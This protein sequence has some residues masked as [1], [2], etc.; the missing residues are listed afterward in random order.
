MLG[1]QIFSHTDKDTYNM[2]K[3]SNIK[4]SQ[5]ETQKTLVPVCHKTCPVWVHPRQMLKI[6]EC[7]FGQSTKYICFVIKGAKDVCT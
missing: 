7:G 1:L 5:N 6:D 4:D 2:A 3:Q